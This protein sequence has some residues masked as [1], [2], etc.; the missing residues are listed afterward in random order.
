MHFPAHQI[1]ALAMPATAP[2]DSRLPT[3]TVTIVFTDIEGSTALWEQ[4]PV[5]MQ[6]AL[7]RHDRLL[8]HAIGSFGGCIVKTTGD[9]VLAVFAAAADALA[10]CVAAQRALQAPEAD[11][12]DPEPAAS[13]ARMPVSL[14][15]RMGLHTGVAE[16]RDGDYFGGSL[17]RAARIMS[18]ANGEQI[19]LSV[20]TAE[21]ARGLLPEGVTLREM[22]EHRLKG[23]LDPERLLQ[24]VAPERRTCPPCAADMMRA[25]R[26]STVPK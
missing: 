4:F 16:L 10:A 5:A 17:N 19:L 3:G 6:A 20:A 21:L 13:D 8:R 18:A 25:A 12:S 15:V 24:V 1:P 14:K 26:L 2:A 11:A 23:L 22:G 9:G 7:A